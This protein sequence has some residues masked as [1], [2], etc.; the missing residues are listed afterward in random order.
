MTHEGVADQIRGTK[1][2]SIIIF[3]EHLH[4]D[5]ADNPKYARIENHLLDCELLRQAKGDY[6]FSRDVPM[7]DEV[8]ELL[9]R[10]AVDTS[11]GNHHDEKEHYKFKD[12]L[13]M[14]YY[15][16]RYLL[17]IPEII[18]AEKEMCGYDDDDN[19]ILN[20]LVLENK[21]KQRMEEIII[22]RTQKTWE[23]VYDM[24]KPLSHWD[25]RSSF[26]QHF[27]IDNGNEIL[28]A[29][30]NYGSSGARWDLGIMIHAFAMQAE[31][32]TYVMVYNEFNELILK[33]EYPRQFRCVHP[34]Y[35][36][37]YHID[38]DVSNK[39][40]EGICVNKSD[41]VKEKF[42][43]TDDSAEESGV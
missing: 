38:R 14:Q 15:D 34:H 24:P 31:V 40:V 10:H 9:N 28:H 35:G 25:Y 36:C 7:I 20:E 13:E 30:G 12:E 37:N 17:K 1:L 6:P 32:T 22:P 19:P 27:F 21:I 8:R 33:E 3:D 29:A 41:Y 11:A 5:L 4:D 42:Y 16:N 18:E 26:H 39:L 2:Y 23:R 43:E